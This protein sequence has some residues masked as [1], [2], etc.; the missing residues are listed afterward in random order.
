M[1]RRVACVAFGAA[2][3]A[4]ARAAPTTKLEQAPSCDILIAGGSLASL[5]AAL[6]AANASLLLSPSA[7][8]SVCLLEITD[9]LGGQATASGTSAI[10]LGSTW[11]AFPAN[12]PRAFADALTSAALGPADFNPGGCTVSKKC[13]LPQLFS[14]WADA[15]AAALPNLRVLRSTAVHGVAR[16]HATGR[17][18]RVSAV[19]RTPTAAHAS[20]WDRLLSAALPDWYSPT[21]SEYFTK[22]VVDFEVPANGGVVIE[23]TEF[24]DVL[25]LGDLNVTQGG[26]EDEASAAPARQSCG[27]ATTVCFW[28]RWGASAAPSPD[29]WPPGSDGGHAIP[30]FVPS[31][32][33][34]SL[35]FSLTWRR[36]LAADPADVKTP[37][38][39]DVAL[40]NGGLV[41]SNDEDYA[42]V[43]LPVE[44]ARA[45]AAL[46]AYA[47]GVDLLAL[48]MAE[49]RAYAFY[50]HI[51]A[52]L[53]ANLPA[54]VGFLTLNASA[55]GTQTGLAKMPY[56]RDTRRGAAGLG[57]FRL[58]H[59]F[60]APNGTGPGPAGCG[61]GSAGEP[62]P[63]GY[64]WHWNDTIALGSYD[65]DIHRM[66]SCE[67]PPYLYFCYPNC[68][69]GLPYYLPWRALTH[70]QAPNLLLAGKTM[71]QSFYA[72]A[73]TRLHPSEWSSGAAAGAGAALMAA[74][75]WS[76]AD[77]FDNVGVLQDLLVK[78]GVPIEWTL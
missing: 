17:I 68:S 11:Q 22:S 40:L 54:A 27:Q 13:F 41:D 63:T 21:D 44:E 6:T 61:L 23:G 37:R 72:N 18:V 78:V 39:G 29:P 38:V 19:T 34:G 2:F 52:A 71:S 69:V 43:F 66:K 60:A 77:V 36:S 65:F 14:S 58:C 20:G 28:P 30:S 59:F 62:G 32:P 74:R 57:G 8:A 55:A 33:T 1:S 70:M 67:L 15:A 24:G 47:G 5:A 10:D 42:Y 26:E 9:W 25:L 46:G 12:L 3:L 64:G 45:S 49:A 73:I 4:S 7:P 48:A 53:P 75:A 35:P 31:S 51:V 56:L 50:H 16:D 76:S